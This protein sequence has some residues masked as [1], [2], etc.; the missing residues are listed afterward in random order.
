MSEEKKKFVKITSPVGELGAFPCIRKPDETYGHYG[1]K[2]LLEDTPATAEFLQR[3]QLIM[4]DFEKTLS[5]KDKKRLSSHPFYEEELDE[6]GEETGRLLLQF[7]SKHAPAVFDCARP[8]NKVDDSVDPWRGSKVRVS[9]SVAGFTM[10]A[11]KLWGLTKYLNAVQVV[12]LSNGSRDASSYGFDDDLAGY[13][14]DAGI[15]Q[16]RVPKGADAGPDEDGFDDDVA[17]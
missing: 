10:P 17:F 11:T 13:E 7:R 16:D 3:L 12:E 8:P 14:A 5:P 9:M 15:K 6:E 1:V 4:N 2:L